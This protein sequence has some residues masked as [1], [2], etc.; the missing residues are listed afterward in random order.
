MS[1]TK[2]TPVFIQLLFRAVQLA[3]HKNSNSKSIIEP[4][5]G[6]GGQKFFV[7]M[8]FPKE[9]YAQKHELEQKLLK[10]LTTGILNDRTISPDDFLK[11]DTYLRRYYP[12]SVN[13]EKAIDKYRELIGQ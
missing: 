5:Y 8:I 10:A 7:D 6:Y 12:D 3:F 11:I 4:C 13:C 2:R 9:V 1:K